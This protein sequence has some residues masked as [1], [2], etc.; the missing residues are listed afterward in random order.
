MMHAG[1]SGGRKLRGILQVVRKTSPDLTLVLEDSEGPGVQ[2]FC[3]NFPD[4]LNFISYIH[5]AM[6][7]ITFEVLET[8]IK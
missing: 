5:S 1:R 7:V 8:F 2:V 4:Q 6:L 3:S